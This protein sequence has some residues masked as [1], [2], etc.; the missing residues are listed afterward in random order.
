[1]ATKEKQ[2]VPALAVF[3]VVTAPEDMDMAMTLVESIAAAGTKG[4]ATAGGGGD[5]PMAVQVAVKPAATAAAAV[6]ITVK[7]SVKMEDVVVRTTLGIFSSA[8]KRMD[9]EEQGSD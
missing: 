5:K 2:P 6:V 7:G 3:N 9:V 8:W 4:A 1:M